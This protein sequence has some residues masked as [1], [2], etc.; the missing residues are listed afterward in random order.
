MDSALIQLAK[1]LVKDIFMFRTFSCS[2]NSANKQTL[3]VA[4]TV[5]GW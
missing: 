3:P 1:D 2:N 5:P 4:L